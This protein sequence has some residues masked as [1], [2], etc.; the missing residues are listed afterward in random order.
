LGGQAEC[1]HKRLESGAYIKLGGTG[2]GHGFERPGAVAV[3]GIIAE[4]ADAAT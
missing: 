1:L 2:L 3:E 4:G